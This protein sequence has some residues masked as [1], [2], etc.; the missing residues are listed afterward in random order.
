MPNSVKQVPGISQIL[1]PWARRRLSWCWWQLGP[2]LFSAE[3]LV[4]IHKK[5]PAKMALLG[6]S[7]QHCI[8]LH[9]SLQCNFGVPGNQVIILIDVWTNFT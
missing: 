2:E 5:P 3:F 4:C 7:G 8:F 9:M 1:C 6:S